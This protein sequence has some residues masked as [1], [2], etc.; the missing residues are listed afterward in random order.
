MYKNEKS[1]DH[2]PKQN[3]ECTKMKKIKKSV[4]IGL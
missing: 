3:E 1:C 4:I 2:W